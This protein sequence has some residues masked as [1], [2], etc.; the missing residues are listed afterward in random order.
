MANDERNQN[1]KRSW[2][3]GGRVRHFHPKFEIYRLTIDFPII[4]TTY[5]E[6]NGVKISM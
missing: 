4:S 3:G 1:K 5:A 6:S 2:R